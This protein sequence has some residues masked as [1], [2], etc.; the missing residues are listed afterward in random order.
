LGGHDIEITD[1][2]MAA[3]IY[4]RQQIRERHRHRYELNQAYL[5]AFEKAGLHLT[6]FSDDRKRTEILEIREH[7][8]Y[9]ATQF[10]PEY[11]SRPGKP[12]PSYFNFVKAAASR[13]VAVL[14]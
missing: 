5:L 6:A 8:F 9:F 2:T 14:A 10:H 12:E 3:R 13:K 4:Q 11:I 1:G 7:P